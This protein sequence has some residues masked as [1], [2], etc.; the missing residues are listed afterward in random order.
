MSHTFGQND[1]KV[2]T[3]FADI[4]Q[5]PP[6]GPQIKQRI[7]STT[8]RV[9]GLYDAYFS[10]LLY[11]CVDGKKATSDFSIFLNTLCK[12][13]TTKNKKKQKYNLF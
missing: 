2:N 7:Y 13:T 3:S 1:Q 10:H 5:S 12:K 4:W 8:F 6:D 9:T 11:Y